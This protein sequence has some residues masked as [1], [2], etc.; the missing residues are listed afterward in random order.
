MNGETGTPFTYRLRTEVYGSRETAEQIFEKTRAAII[1]QLGQPLETYE[2]GQFG[3]DFAVEVNGGR[4]IRI[5][6][7]NTATGR[8]R[9]GIPQ[10]LDRQVRMELQYGPKFPNVLETM[11]SIE[12]LR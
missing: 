12:D 8:A 2:Q 9:F 7:W 3:T 6:E 5:M 1:K 4:L 11:W 10:R